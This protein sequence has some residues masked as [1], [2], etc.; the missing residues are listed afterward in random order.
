MA[1]HARDI[2]NYKYYVDSEGGRREILDQ[3]LS[4]EKRKQ[5]SRYASRY[6]LDYQHHLSSKSTSLTSNSATNKFKF[7]TLVHRSLH[8]AGPQYLSSLLHPYTPSRHLRSA[9]LNLLSQPQHCS[10]LSTCWPFSLEFFSFIISY[11]P[12]LTLSSNPI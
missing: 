12:T 10:W 6:S 8:N 9:S 7:A 3:L 1:A 4:D 5:L 2:L 11:L